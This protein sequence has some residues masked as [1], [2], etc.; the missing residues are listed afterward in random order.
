MYPVIG[1]A[2]GASASAISAAAASESGRCNT[3]NSII[4]SFTG[5]TGEPK[6]S[7]IAKSLWCPALAADAVLPAHRRARISA[8]SGRAGLTKRSAKPSCP[9]LSRITAINVRNNV[10]LI[11]V[12][13]ISNNDGASVATVSSIATLA[14][15]AAVTALSGIA[16]FPT[17]TNYASTG[18]AV[19]AAFALS[20][21]AAVTARTALAA[22][23]SFS[24][25][26]IEFVGRVGV[27]KRDIERY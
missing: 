12:R 15:L 10:L 17:V 19:A 8:N 20:A 27:L 7:D 18:D 11:V 25:T 13:R 23:A 26:G 6:S 22:I 9:R 24:S 4:S 14:A 21:M 3:G 16:A 1:I 2:T 5:G